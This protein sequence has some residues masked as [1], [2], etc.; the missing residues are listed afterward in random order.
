M[1]LSAKIHGKSR[2]GTLRGRAFWEIILPM[3]YLDH[4]AT[5]PLRPE[6]RE[7]MLPL[8]EGWQGNP[9]GIHAP[10]RRFRAAIDGSRDTIASLLGAKSH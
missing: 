4:N 2:V 3:I 9:S 5:T 7:A 8:M 6:A 10:G 1:P